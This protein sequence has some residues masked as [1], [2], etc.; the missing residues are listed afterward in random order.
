MTGFERLQGIRCSV[1][2]PYRR[3]SAKAHSPLEHIGDAVGGPSRIFP[4]AT[5]A[6]PATAHKRS[7]GAAEDPQ[8][9]LR[10]E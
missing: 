4:S 3:C 8:G 2:V 10:A 9:V 7:T 5:G 6:S 1:K